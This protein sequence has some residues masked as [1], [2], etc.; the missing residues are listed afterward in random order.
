MEEQLNKEAA[1]N[2]DNQPSIRTVYLVTYSQAAA[3]W[4]RESLAEAVVSQ[5]E[6]GQA[7]V[8]QWVCSEE[9]HQAGGRHFHLAIKLGRPKRWLR[10]RNQLQI[11][12]D[13]NVNFSSTHSNYF[14]AW[15]Y[16]TKEDENFVESESHPD[17]SA[18]FV[19][20]TA[21]AINRRRSTSSPAAAVQNGVVKKRR[22]DTLD[23]SDVIV[24]KNIK[25]KADLLRLANEQKNEGKRD[26]PLY[27]F[28]NIDKCTK[29]IQT[30]WEMI[31]VRTQT[32]REMKTRMELLEVYLASDCVPLCNGQWLE[33]SVETLDRNNTTPGFFAEAVRCLLDRGRGKHRNLLITGP[34]NCGKTFLLSPLRKVYQSFV[35]PAQN[36]FAWVGAERAEIISLNDLRWTEKLIPWNNFLQLLEG[37]DVHLSVPKN[38]APEDVLFTR[39]TPIFATSISKIR[40]YCAGVVHELETEM[41]DARWNTFSF[42]YQLKK[43]QVR[44]LRPCPYCFA[45]L[46]LEH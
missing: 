32:E 2:N 22:F 10:V 11:D 16:A 29:L 23:V 36:T 13:I 24:A 44:E 33:R 6:Q 37:A 19:P 35:N 5:F 31:N 45:R 39:D 4:T 30:T 7:N 41:M 12:H 27:V 38:H 14:D 1:Q 3:E 43:S 42:H 15:E 20:R 17:L 40:K 21:S 9:Q 25:T 26:L 18:G 46:I 8:K 34:A 28:N